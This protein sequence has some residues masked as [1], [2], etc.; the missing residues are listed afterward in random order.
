MIGIGFFGFLVRFLYNTLS[1]IFDII[2][3]NRSE[4]DYIPM[5]NT[6]RYMGIW[7]Y[8]Q[9]SLY[10]FGDFMVTIMVILFFFPAKRERKRRVR[11]LLE[12]LRSSQ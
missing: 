10:F 5:E 3:L 9:F 7:T 4:D 2:N 6:F 1:L 11:S 12:S 8:L